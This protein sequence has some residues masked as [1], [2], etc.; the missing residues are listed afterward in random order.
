MGDDASET[1]AVQVVVRCR[2]LASHEEHSRDLQRPRAQS[3]L[4]VVDSGAGT[5]SIKSDAAA[6]LP[7][8]FAFDRVFGS[9]ATQQE[10]YQGAARAAVLSVTNGFNS[11]VLAYG[12]TG[13][14]KWLPL[15]S[16]LMVCSRQ[17]CTCNNLQYP[18]VLH[19]RQNA[20]HAGL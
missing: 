4:M 16:I 17:S 12:Q 5:I 9:H 1:A 6:A 14:G 8:S 13:S 2:P 20:H 3:S 19:G 7:R 11:T 15:N 18:Y 10:V